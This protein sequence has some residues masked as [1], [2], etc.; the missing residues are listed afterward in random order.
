MYL[1]L[2]FRDVLFN[3]IISFMLIMIII[4]GMIQEEKTSKEDSM[5]MGSIVA[6]LTWPDGDQ[7]LDLWVNGPNEPKPIG[8]SNKA[9][10]NID[11]L[12]DDMGN[13]SDIL[14]L[15]Y[16]NAIVRNLQAGTYTFNIHCYRC[17]SGFPIKAV[18]EVRINRL[19]GP[20]YVTTR[21][22]D[23]LYEGQETTVIA[24]DMDSRG[25]VD[26]PSVNDVM[27][28]LRSAVGE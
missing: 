26:P 15:N 5:A 8:Y 25:Y 1:H 9:G 21:M 7:D 23:I 3:V 4:M 11:L 20:P 17:M 10:E 16:E 2:A 19:E 12:R 22:V 28:K 13:I 6:T 24:F 14:P 18:L 27:V